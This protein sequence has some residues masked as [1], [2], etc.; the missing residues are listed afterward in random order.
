MAVP[1]NGR[2]SREGNMKE[3]NPQFR[4]LEM[5]LEKS[6]EEP[7]LLLVR[8]FYYITQ[9]NRRKFIVGCVGALA[10]MFMG[11]A[12]ETKKIGKRAAN[13][14]R[15]VKEY[16]YP[17]EQTTHMMPC[18]SP[19]PQNAVCACNCVMATHPG[20]D[21]KP[22]AFTNSGPYH[23]PPVIVPFTDSGPYHKPPATVP[24]TDSGP[25]HKPTETVPFSNTRSWSEPCGSPIPPG[26]I[27]T[28]N[29]V[30]VRY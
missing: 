1:T 11:C 21:R 27:C 18:D 9:L 25:Y 23:K 30:P 8:E 14:A 6:G 15:G 26:A 20:P 22:P 5:S 12:K 13:R 24:F 29:C 17:D 2:P 16:K 4:I 19:L 10:G 7:R 28:C 3:I